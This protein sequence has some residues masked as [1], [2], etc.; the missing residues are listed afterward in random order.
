MFVRAGKEERKGGREKEL[1]L[2]VLN[3]IIIRRG[4]RLVVLEVLCIV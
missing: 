4:I 2:M 1:R 3:N